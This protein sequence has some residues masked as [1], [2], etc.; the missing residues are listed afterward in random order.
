MYLITSLITVVILQISNELAPLLFNS[1]R[2]SWRNIYNSWGG[3][4]VNHGE[5]QKSANDRNR[6][7]MKRPRLAL[8]LKVTE[9]KK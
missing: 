4:V 5:L 9:N 6:H 7:L 8:N 2:N 1:M 3:D